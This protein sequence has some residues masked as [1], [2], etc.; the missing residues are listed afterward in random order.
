M[1]RQI[2]FR[3]QKPRSKIW[4]EG[5]LIST[6]IMK[7]IATSALEVFP[8]Q[9]DTLSQ[10]INR[11]DK[12]G[13]KAFEGDFVKQTIIQDDGE[14]LTDKF[15]IVFDNVAC[16]FVMVAVDFERR[17]MKKIVYDIPDEKTFS[18]E[19]EVIGNRWDNWEEE[20]YLPLL[21]SGVV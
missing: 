9:K 8:F 14:I 4:V 2:L 7:G 1:K 21:A 11:T 13:K 18:A 16:A 5:D 3:G 15:L 10:Y 20:Q 17:G 12:N 6:G 19:I